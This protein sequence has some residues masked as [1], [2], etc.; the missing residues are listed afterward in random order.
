MPNYNLEQIKTKINEVDSLLFDLDGTLIDTEPLYFRFWKEASKLNGY[1]LSDKEA[2]SMRS[3]DVNSAISFLNEVSHGVLDYYKTKQ[4]RIELMS[5][6]IEEHPI[7]MKLGAREFLEKMLLINK[8]LYIVT[9]NTVEKSNRILSMLDLHKYFKGVISAKDVKRGKPYP[10]VY[11][12]ACELINKKPGE[13]IVFEDSPNGLLSSHNANCFTVMVEDLDK[14]NKDI[15]Y[16]DAA[17][18]SFKELL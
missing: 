17:I 13:V 1:E 8:D 10:D 9:A 11:L 16:V 6:Y 2:L 7:Q 14:Y 3:R 15:D 4:T 18:E 12:K 5:K